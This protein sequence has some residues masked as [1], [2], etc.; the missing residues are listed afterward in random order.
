[1]CKLYKGQEISIVV[2]IGWSFISFQ[3]LKLW[4]GEIAQLVRAWG[5]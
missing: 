3:H 5:R 2:A 4:G 1:M